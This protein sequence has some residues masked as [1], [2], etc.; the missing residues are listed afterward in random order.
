MIALAR[1]YQQATN[2]HERQPPIRPD[3]AVPKLAVLDDQFK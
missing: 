3:T 1:A 2:W